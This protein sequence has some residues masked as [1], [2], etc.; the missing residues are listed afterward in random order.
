[1]ASAWLLALDAYA[2]AAACKPVAI[3][4]L[5]PHAGVMLGEVHG[6]REAPAFLEQLVCSVAAHRAVVLALEYPRGEQSALDAFFDNPNGSAAEAQL[7]HT[8]FWSLATKDGRQSKA[9]LAVLR[10]VRAWRR[11]GLPITVTAY[12]GAP[13]PQQR[14]AVNAAFL[15]DLL[16]KHQGRAFVVIYSG[17]V[18]TMR[19]LFEDEPEL[20][21]GARLSNWDLLHLTMVTTGGQAWFC[22]ESCGVH[23]WPASRTVPPPTG[24]IRLGYPTAAF[25]GV[26]GVGPI[27][28]SPPA[29]QAPANHCSRHCL[30]PN[31][32]MYRPG[33]APTV[34]AGPD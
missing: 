23:D 6:T 11:Q 15:D 9:W 30:S 12:D 29:R 7:L 27:T 19:T 33:V 14:E 28:A 22:G 17:N 21:M 25:D 20:P 3:D 4:L 24:T 13:T 26:F 16:Q 2:A 32:N 34:P 18:H 5:M 10:D 8:H 1:M 31:L